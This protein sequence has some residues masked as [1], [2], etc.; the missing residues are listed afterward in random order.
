MPIINDCLQARSDIT[1]FTKLNDNSFAFST[2]YHGAKIITD[3]EC[4]TGSS[5]KDENLNFNT[6]AICF[7]PDAKLIA[8]AANNYL[9]IADIQSKKVIKSIYTEKEQLTILN[10]D[11]SSQYIIAGNKEGRVLLYKYNSSLHLAR[12]CS[13]PYQRPKTKVKKNFV[14]SMAFH[15]NLLAVSGY[16]GAIFIIDIYSGANKTVLLHGTSRKQ[17]LH[18]LNENTIISGDN[19]GNLQ[20]ISIR[21][22]S[23]IKNINLPFRKTK[24]IIAIPNTKFLIVHAGLNNMIIVD[25]KEYKI[26]QNNYLELEDNIDFI[27]AIDNKTL[28]V[29]LQNKNILH[30]E[31]P[32]RDRLHSLILHNA[33]DDAYELVEK[34]PMLQDTPEYRSLEKIYNKAYLDAANA[35]INQNK[36]LANQLTEIYNDVTSKKESIKLLFKSFENYNRFKTL[37]LEKK[38]CSLLCHVFKISS[39]EDNKTI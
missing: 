4:A 19:E 15:K 18:F 11:L 32:S 14:S 34:E 27:E 25:S 12:L 37:Y 23:I 10:F 6:S 7:S 33:L 1:A 30:I 29:C 35:L 24:Q 17:T 9:Y 28:L 8:Y 16:G 22:N 5:F 38:I 26:L 20:L 21:D 2:K 13:F 3:Q 31:L 36:S 39:V